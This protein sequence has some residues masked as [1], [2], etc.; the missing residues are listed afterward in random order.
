MREAVR[1]LYA[2]NLRISSME[3]GPLVGAMLFGCMAE[4]ICVSESSTCHCDVVW[5]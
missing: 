3:N 4:V 2:C 1:I 5:I